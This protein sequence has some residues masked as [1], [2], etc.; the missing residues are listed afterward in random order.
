MIGRDGFLSVMVSPDCS[1]TSIWPRNSGRCFSTGS[2]TASFPSSTSIMMPMAVIGLVIEAI[3]KRV[4]D[5]IGRSFST[6]RRPMASRLTTPS[7]LP[8][9][10]TIP[11]T[12]FLSTN[13]CICS[14][15]RDESAGSSAWA[16]TGTAADRS[17]P[18]PG[19][20]A[21]GEVVG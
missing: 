3:R 8:T 6:S 20:S 10:V 16:G 21:R 9:R 7:G 14:R 15:I 13:G 18:A 5:R 12:S 2:S 19:G 17:R 1:A 11:A 4:S